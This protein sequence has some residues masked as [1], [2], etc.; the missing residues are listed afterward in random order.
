MITRSYDGQRQLIGVQKEKNSIIGQTLV[1]GCQ[2][3][4]FFP[5]II[6]Y[7]FWRILHNNQNEI[8]LWSHQDFVFLALDPQIRK[9]VGRIQIPHDGFGSLGK[10]RDKH[11]VLKQ[12]RLR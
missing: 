11:R 12:E 8:F 4:F 2:L 6:L 7:W 1:R 10:L 9:L 5:L 3:L